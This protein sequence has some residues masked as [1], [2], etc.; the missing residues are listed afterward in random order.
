MHHDHAENGSSALKHSSD[1]DLLLARL[2]ACTEQRYSQ[3]HFSFMDLVIATSL[4]S[5]RRNVRERLQDP[6]YIARAL[7]G[8]VIVCS[9]IAFAASPDLFVS[10]RTWESSCSD[11]LVNVLATARKR[12]RYTHLFRGNVE[13]IIREGHYRITVSFTDTTTFSGDG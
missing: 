9:R 2:A 4:P 10:V 5:D 7:S 13:F 3:A 1:A 8:G 12:K 11:N 6:E